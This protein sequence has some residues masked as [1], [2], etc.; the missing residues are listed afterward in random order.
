MAISKIILNGVTQMDLTSDTV[1]ANNLISPNTAHDAA[2]LPVVGTA[3]GGSPTLQSKTATPTESV[4]TITPDSGYDG[5]SDVEVGAISSTYVGTGIA[6]R[7]ASDLTIEN[8]TANLIAVDVPGGYYDQYYYK[9]IPS[10]TAGTPT[11]TKGTV[12]NHSVTVTPSVTNTPGYITGG[13]KT[14]TAVTVTASELDS[15]TKQIAQNGQGI[16]VV[17]YASVDVNVPSGSPTLQSKSAT[18][19]ESTQTVTADNGYDGLSSVE[20][21]AI[22]STYVGSG[23]TRRS[24]SDVTQGQVAG[25]YQVSVPAG[26]Y[27]SA[28]TKYVPPGTAGT[29]SAT[30]GTVSNHQVSVTPSVTNTAGYIRSET[31][32][33]TAVTVTAAELASG[34][35]AIVDNG[36]N[37]DVVGYSTVSVAVPFSAI[38]VSSSNPTGGSNGDVWIK[39]S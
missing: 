3:S 38:T 19:T 16:D 10:G 1:A 32:D 14:G 28:V 36:T 31:K 24:S 30:K 9:E 29:P 23:I 21:G 27:A 34:N 35:K 11:A 5:L 15:G 4:Q 17:G 8:I 6:R 26:Y 2:G 7:T 25:E 13:T 20:V 12:S 22:S 18:P 37:I 33:G 39:T